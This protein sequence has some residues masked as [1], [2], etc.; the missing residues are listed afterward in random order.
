MTDATLAPY[1]AL[2]PYCQEQQLSG[3]L[4]GEEQLPLGQVLPP[5]P[6]TAIGLSITTAIKSAQT[7]GPKTG[8]ELRATQTAAFRG[9][10]MELQEE[11]SRKAAL[12]DNGMLIS[13][14]KAIEQADSGQRILSDLPSADE[15]LTVQQ[16]DQR[17]AADREADGDND[18]KSVALHRGWVR[19]LA[20]MIA[21]LD[22]ALYWEF[23]FN[24]GALDSAIAVLKWAAAGCLAVIWATAMDY[25]LHAYQGRERTSRERRSTLRDFHRSHRRVPSGQAARAQDA[26]IRASIEAA[27][28]AT[29]HAY[30]LVLVIIL[31]NVLL[32][33]G[34]VASMVRVAGRSV[35][36]A[37]IF[38]MAAGLF[39]CLIFAAV[40]ILLTRGNDLGEQ[41]RDNAARLAELADRYED[42][43]Q[44]AEDAAVRSAQSRALAKL[45]GAHGVDDR[46][47]VMAAYWR[48][49]E[50]AAADLSLA[51]P[52]GPE[53]VV[54]RPMPIQEEGLERVEQAGKD[55]DGLRESLQDAKKTLRALRSP[56]GSEHITTE[57]EPALPAQAPE[58]TQTVLRALA[59]VHPERPTAL[60][61]VPLVQGPDSPPPEPPPLPH[62]IGYVALAG[63]FVGLAAALI[64]A[65]VT[66]SPTDTSG[67]VVLTGMHVRG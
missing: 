49:M 43:V 27:D 52:V 58:N 32:I 36:E 12:H 51:V 41:M 30:W 14:Q 45:A 7:G 29:R 17:L 21:I 67:G 61:P 55:L 60:V 25:T 37:T 3:R 54:A 24:L 44:D 10:L 66:P 9:A 63:A 13:G 35:P 40:T 64:M 57:P 1:S 46:L 28:H 8:D 23:I 4:V 65:L 5:L 6:I 20:C 34:R 50:W 2:C 33:S 42:S 39:I 56:V 18:H 22:V 16:D 38:G 15:A 62:R 11:A 47:G 59:Q 26:A 53:D 48:A 19:F 31:V